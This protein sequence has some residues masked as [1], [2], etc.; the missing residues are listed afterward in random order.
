MASTLFAII[1]P[2]AS[3]GF[4]TESRAVSTADRLNYVMLQQGCEL[5][6]GRSDPAPRN[7]CGSLSLLIGA[8]PTDISPRL[9]KEVHRDAVGEVPAPSVALGLFCAGPL[10]CCACFA[11]CLA[12]LRR[13]SLAAHAALGADP[14]RHSVRHV[15]ASV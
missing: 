1:L 14:A 7:G 5:V 6:L 2:H 13:P 9:T 15:Q 4:Q 11:G 12:A 8:A 3:M 10:L